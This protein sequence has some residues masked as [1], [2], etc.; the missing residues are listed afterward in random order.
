MWRRPPMG[1][2]A[3]KLHRSKQRPEWRTGLTLREA[4]ILVS[5]Q[6]EAEE[7]KPEPR[8]LTATIYR[9]AMVVSLSRY[10]P[11]SMRDKLPSEELLA[12]SDGIE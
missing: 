5:E 4:L 12:E 11:P 1:D 2:Y 7:R 9:S 6:I 3:L 10:F 8:Y